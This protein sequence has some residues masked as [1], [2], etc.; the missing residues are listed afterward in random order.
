MTSENEE[1]NW[2]HQHQQKVLEKI[3]LSELTWNQR[4]Q[5]RVL[6]TKENSAFSVDDNSIGINHQN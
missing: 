3:D 4:E 6:I 2:D 1:K 5:V